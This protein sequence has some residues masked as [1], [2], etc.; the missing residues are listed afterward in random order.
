MCCRLVCQDN[1][2]SFGFLEM[3]ETNF[4]KQFRCSA[5][6]S[7]TDNIEVDDTYMPI[8]KPFI[9]I[10]PMDIPTFTKV[11]KRIPRTKFTKLVD[12]LKANLVDDEVPLAQNPLNRLGVHLLKGIFKEDVKMK[13]IVEG[14]DRIQNCFELVVVCWDLHH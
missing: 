3:A 1:R 13:E 9:E 12:I 7:F 14:K 8:L 4:P 11:L 6:V 10:P 2:N 5:A